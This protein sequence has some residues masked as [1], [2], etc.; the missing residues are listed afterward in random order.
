M[1]SLCKFLI[2]TPEDLNK[3][4]EIRKNLIIP[5]SFCIIIIIIILSY[6]AGT[7]EESWKQR[8]IKTESQF[9]ALQT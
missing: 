3:E 1:L 4:I 8:S 7:N 2:Q 6:H 9:G 5:S